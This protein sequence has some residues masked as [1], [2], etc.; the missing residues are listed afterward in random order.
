MKFDVPLMIPAIHSIRLA[1]SPSRS[2]LMIGMPP[3]TAPSKA[4]MTPF[5]C[6]AAKISLPCRLDAADQLDDDIDVAGL[7][8]GPRVGRQVD[9]GAAGDIARASQRRIGDPRDSDRTPRTPRDL[10]LV[11]A[12]HGPGAEPH[13]ADAEESHLQRLECCVRHRGF[14]SLQLVFA[15]HLLDAANCLPR[16]VLV[17]Y[18]REPH[19]AV[20][21]LAEADPRR[22]R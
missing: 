13:G 20:A 14:A 7:E 2:A 9:I 1:V 4:T 15:E 17:F 11:P 16:S 12:Q 5:A 22:H 19:V 8:H 18:H 21:E 6:A 10:L 3:A